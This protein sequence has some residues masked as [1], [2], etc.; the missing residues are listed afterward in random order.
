MRQ[1]AAMALRNLSRSPKRGAA[2]LCV[3]AAA[4][5]A[6][7][8]IQAGYADLFDRVRRGQA[9]EDGDLWF[10]AAG[11]GG[12]GVGEYEGLKSRLLSEGRVARVA[13]SVPL[14][15]LVGTESRSAPASGIAVEGAFRD[16]KDGE[17]FVKAELGKA[18]AASLE[19]EEGAEFS[20]LLGDA[21]FSLRLES[22]V[23]TEAEARDRFYIRLPLEALSER[24]LVDRVIAIRLW[25]GKADAKRIDLVREISSLPALKGYECHAYELGNT[26]ANSIINVYRDNFLVVLVAVGFTML[27][28]LGNVTLLST[29]ERGEEWGTLLAIGTPF[30]SL[31]LLLALE[32][33][34]LAALAAAAG[35][36]LTLGICG[37]VNALGGLTFPPPPTSTS[38]IH[39][40]LKPEAGALLQATGLAFACAFSAALLAGQGLR[41][42]PIL[43]L[44]CERN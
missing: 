2:L 13:A 24:G 36:V 10:E 29:W 37:L 19:L 14:Q 30:R 16:W 32:A 33:L 41:R 38:P 22:A 4:F 20:A 9:S 8:L 26:A 15:G 17:G 6:L 11:A 40:D 34:V 28:A 12:M 43:E 23:S 18:L 35:I 7:T 39:L 44:L 42:K 1:E 31:R 27:L 3:V 5:L 25:A 21:G